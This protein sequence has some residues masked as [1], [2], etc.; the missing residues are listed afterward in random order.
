MGMTRPLWN[1]PDR[2][3]CNSYLTLPQLFS[4]SWNSPR[5]KGKPV[6]LAW[7]VRVDPCPGELPPKQMSFVLEGKFSSWNGGRLAS[8]RRF[9]GHKISVVPVAV[10]SIKSLE[11]SLWKAF[12]EFFSPLEFAFSKSVHWSIYL[13]SGLCAFLKHTVYYEEVMETLQKE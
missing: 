2:I 12:W 8:S 10:P 13:L 6:L 11:F 3:S 9:R 1:F 7:K 5:M 4:E